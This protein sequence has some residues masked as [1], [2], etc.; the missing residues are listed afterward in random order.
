MSG[1]T[2]WYNQMIIVSVISILVVVLLINRKVSIKIIF[3]VIAPFYSIYSISSIFLKSYQTF[4]IWLC[5][6]IVTILIVIF[7]IK[8]INKYLSYTIITLIILITRIFVMPN[9]FAKL[10][11][12]ESYSKYNFSQAKFINEKKEI[13][14]FNSLSNSIVV[15][16]IW[17]SACAPCFKMFPDLEKLNNQYLNDSIVKIYSLGIPLLIDK[18]RDPNILLAKYNFKKL[19]F[20]DTFQAE[21]LGIE[22]VPIVLVFNKNGK[23]VYAGDLNINKLI[24]ISN[25][26]DIIEK[27]RK[28]D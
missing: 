13:V 1:I 16:E 10:Y 12:I 9:V 18:N 2:D 14:K 19:R 4:A 5:G 24:K 7:Y 8:K 22:A 23:C 17:H 15:F 21:K 6:L 26:I 28:N 20:M 27:Q 11:T 25:I 3:A